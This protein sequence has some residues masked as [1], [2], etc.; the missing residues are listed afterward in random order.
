M[1]VT[2]PY[3][4]EWL[5]DILPISSA[6]FDIKRNDK[7][8]GQG[9]GRIWQSE[10]ADPLWI[11]DIE[12]DDATYTRDA[13][14]YAARIRKLHGA[15][16]AFFLYDPVSQYPASDPNG[17][18]LGAAA[19]SIASI[20]A[21]SASLSLT[22]LPAGYQLT[23]GDK[24]CLTYGTTPTLYAFFEVSEPV[25]AD[26]AGTTPEFGIF[27]HI[28]TGI[29]AGMAV[30]LARPYCRMVIEPESHRPG[31]ARRTLT[32]GAGFRAIQKR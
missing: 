1:T 28:S 7:I 21:D 10:L 3:S 26:A 12:L 9:R 24:F 14:R 18:I 22:G 31:R 30:T 8:S 25:V 16:E 5:A 4:L 6:V 13:K 23:D 29:V 17:S 2:Y 32:E 15:Q 20:G 27:P 11:A 19:V